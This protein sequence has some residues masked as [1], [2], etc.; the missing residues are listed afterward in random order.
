M[1][2]LHTSDWHIGKKVNEFSMIENQRYVMNN[3]YKIIEEESIDVL[4]IA[5]DI[6]DKSIVDVDS[7]NFLDEIFNKIIN[8][9][10]VKI[11]GISGNHDSPDR[12]SFV[13]NILKE[14]GLFLEGDFKGEKKI[15]LNDEFGEVNFYPVSYFDEVYIRNLFS[16]DSI[17]TSNHALH[18]IFN[19]L[20]VDFNKRNIFIGHGYFSNSNMD[21]LLESDSERKLSIGG[22][23]I[24]DSNILESFDYVAL[25]HLHGNQKVIHDHIR[26][27]GS[28]CKYSFSEI[29]QKKVC[30]I[31]DLKNKGN[32]EIKHIP[33]LQKYDMRKI[34][35]FI[36]NL[37][38]EKFYNNLNTL[39]YYQ[40][41][42]LDSIGLID[43]ASKLRKIYKNLMEV[44]FKE[45]E[46]KYNN[47]NTLEIEKISKDPI[48]LFI[49]FYK[50]IEGRDL[51]DEQIKILNEA[52][53]FIRKEEV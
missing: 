5:G 18:K 12:I 11:I 37:L 48:D 15:V 50:S 36:E 13:S 7:I 20:D 31:V 21:T 2:I 46:I 22:Q 39:D 29:N 1:K 42:L 14:K 45:S 19:S 25:G 28:I 8:E 35:G 38:D 30:T 10:K 32:I 40:V 4:V 47:I 9:F 44:R 23:E 41:T 26:Y 49:T 3:I 43:P 52:I 27:S 6:Y 53:K 33:L 51:K 34:E 24:M 17:K 16:D